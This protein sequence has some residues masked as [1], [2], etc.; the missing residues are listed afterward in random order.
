MALSSLETG[1]TGSH[2][3]LH[4]ARAF[5]ASFLYGISERWRARQDLLSLE[6]VPFDVMKDVGF[7]GAERMN[8]K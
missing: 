6:N 3:A 2:G 8:E 4:R 7:P 1:F 5:A